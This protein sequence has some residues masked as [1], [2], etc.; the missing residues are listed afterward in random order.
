MMLVLWWFFLLFVLFIAQF[1]LFNLNQSIE[2]L[3]RIKFKFWLIFMKTSLKIGMNFGITS[4]VITTLWLLVWL[5]AWSEMK[6]IVIAWILTIAIADSFSDALWIHISQ[7]SNWNNSHK[8]VWEATIATFLAKFL[9]ACTFIIP[10]L[11]LPLFWAIIASCIW[12]ISMIT[13]VS[14]KIAKSHKE[15]PLH[16]ILE[17]VFITM[18][19]IVLTYLT[20]IGINKLFS[21][22]ESL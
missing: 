2:L 7:E 8:Q 3:Y 12:W 15:N 16:S 6:S 13:L 10:V 1:I 9:F 19:V 11:A 17:H 20:G 5:A 21:Y 14:Y 18:I 22:T 4:G